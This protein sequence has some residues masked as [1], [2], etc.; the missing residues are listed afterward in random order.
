MKELLKLYVSSKKDITEAQ[1]DYIKNDDDLLFY[2]LVAGN[3]PMNDSVNIEKFYKSLNENKQK[4]L[5][6]RQS[7]YI[8][9]IDNPS[10]QLQLAT[11]KQDGRAIYYIINN[12]IKPSEQV[13]LAAVQQKG[14]AIAYIIHNGI[15]P[16]EQVQLAAVQKDGEAIKFIENPSEQ[17]Q[18]AAVIQDCYAIAH[19]NNPSE[20]VQLAAVEQDSD[21]IE[22]IENPYPSVL[23]Y[24]KS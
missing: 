5:L 16:S 22:Y 3:E 21:V 20:Y 15:I 2:Y 4:Y 24:I 9:Y 12:E 23:N 1:Y 6:K 11:V 18:L 19:I 13:Q 8:E 10:E 14:L 7:K 17:L